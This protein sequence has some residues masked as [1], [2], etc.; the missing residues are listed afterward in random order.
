MW[1]YYS[2]ERCL[3][4]GPR[5]TGLRY[6]EWL[7]VEGGWHSQ[8]S[9]E[10]WLAVKTAEPQCWEGP[11]MPSRPEV[12]ELCSRDHQGCSHTQ[13]E[14]SRGRTFRIWAFLNP[15]SS[16]PLLSIVHI[17]FD[18]EWSLKEVD[19]KYGNKFIQSA[20][21]PQP[22]WAF[23]HQVEISES[24]KETDVNNVHPLSPSPHLLKICAGSRNQ[25]QLT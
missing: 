14:Q 19:G 9:M 21:W 6:R 1:R 7:W 24:M 4:W 23:M 8:D 20:S 13:E 17:G 12:F 15:S 5:G 2:R 16:A 10:A 25:L 22:F 18:L 3:L 11:E